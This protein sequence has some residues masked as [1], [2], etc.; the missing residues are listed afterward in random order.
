MMKET[1]SVMVIASQKMVQAIIDK[2]D[3]PKEEVYE[4]AAKVYTEELKKD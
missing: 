4:L 2:Y 3:L 1:M